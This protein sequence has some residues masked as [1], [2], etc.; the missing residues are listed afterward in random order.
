M[1]THRRSTLANRIA[2]GFVRGSARRRIQEF[3]YNV[4]R[5]GRERFFP[6]GPEAIW[7]LAKLGGGFHH[8]HVEVTAAGNPVSSCEVQ[9]LVGEGDK[10]TVRPGETG[11]ASLIGAE[12]EAPGY[13]LYSYVLL[14]TR[15]TDATQAR[16]LAVLQAY[17]TYIEETRDMEKYGYTPGQLNVA[18]VPVVATP[19][20]DAQNATSP[21]SL[22]AAYNYVRARG[23]CS[24]PCPVHAAAGF[25]SCRRAPRS[26]ITP[27]VPYLIQDL[28]AVPTSTQ[29]LVSWWVREFL[30]QAAQEHFWDQSSP[31]LIGLKMRT[32][33]AVLAEG[34]PDVKHSLSDW[35]SWLH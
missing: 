16:Y 20:E 26:A 27:V 22:L 6:Q 29:N 28:S 23:P 32:V 10:R 2:S 5:I 35:I 12:H 7:S 17:L 15:S 30:D 18:Y 21:A 33:V 31:E 9:V 25:T 8:A 19:H 3:R 13:G 4:E 14:G 1:P 11:R 24:T 34:L